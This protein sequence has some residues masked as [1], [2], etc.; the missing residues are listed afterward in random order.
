MMLS[1]VIPIYN[2]EAYLSECLSSLR[3]Q[4]F[5]DIEFICVDDGSTDGSL[6]IAKR[7]AALDERFRIIT[8]K[9][10]GYGAACNKGLDVCTGKYVAILESDD[11]AEPDFYADLI[12]IAEKNDCDFVK[13]DF[14]RYWDKSRRYIKHKIVD[15]IL[16]GVVFTPC[17]ILERFN[18]LNA[19]TCIWSAVYRRDMIDGKGIRFLITPGASY[20]DLSFSIKVFMSSDRAY[21]TDKA[22]V[23]YRQNEGQSSRALGKPWFVFQEYAEV[24]SQFPMTKAL[25]ASKYHNYLWNYNRLGIEHKYKFLERF[26]NEFKKHLIENESIL[27]EKFFASWEPEQLKLLIKS[28]ISFHDLRIQ[29][30]YEKEKIHIIPAEFPVSGSIPLSKPFISIIVPCYNVERYVQSCL[31][32]LINQ[33]DSE[34][35]EIICVNDSSTDRTLDIL[36]YT[37]KR[38][39]RV[40]VYSHNENRG[41]SAARNTAIKSASGEF[42]LFVDSDD[43]LE[44][45]AIKILKSKIRR[46][47]QVNIINYSAINFPKIKKNDWLKKRFDTYGEYIENGSFYLFFTRKE[48]CPFVWVNM[49]R[50][51]I[52][53]MKGLFFDESIKFGEDTLFLRRLFTNA[54]HVMIIP[55]KLYRYRLRDNSL[56]S[57]VSADNQLN[58]LTKLLEDIEAE[59][60]CFRLQPLIVHWAIDFVYTAIN[61]SPEQISAFIK[62]LKQY[63]Y[64][65]EMKLAPHYHRVMYNKFLNRIR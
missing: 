19:Q 62:L 31:E 16:Y 3:N 22:Y 7:F 61:D 2:V 45:S 65:D 42:I 63:G 17:R 34:D 23:Y 54:E 25:F 18:L 8:G 24:E 29:E 53:D 59:Y 37:S 32:S 50:K 33:E 11:F 47:Q 13:S 1:V 4:T 5:K 9:N 26:S 49:I 43:L 60:S 57:L 10:A 35:I 52:L 40:K 46:E 41:L 58:I 51:S 6:R 27:N 28:P 39:P 15:D 30:L 36:E 48:F 21:F 38:D 64:T 44:T 55:D 20:Q 14:Y 12:E 56:M